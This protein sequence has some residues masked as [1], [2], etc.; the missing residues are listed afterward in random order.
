MQQPL[1]VFL[2]LLLR[3]RL[4]VGD[5]ESLVQEAVTCPQTAHLAN[6]WLSAY[7]ADIA[8]RLTDERQEQDLLPLQQLQLDTVLTPLLTSA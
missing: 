7:A 8:R 6:S 4:P 2:Y 3:D 1:T 5:I